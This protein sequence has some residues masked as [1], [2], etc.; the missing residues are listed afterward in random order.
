MWVNFL[1]Y[2][3]ES[4]ITAAELSRRSGIRRVDT[5]GMERWGYVRVIA[6]DGT[7]VRDL[8]ARAGVAKDITEVSL[9]Y[10]EKQGHAQVSSATGR[11]VAATTDAGRAAQRFAAERLDALDARFEAAREPLENILANTPALRDVLEPHPHSWRAIGPYA[12]QTRRML[13]DPR[14][15]LAHFP[16]VTH[17]GGYPD[18]S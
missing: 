17:R 4:G 14:A 13:A 9:G 18:G 1:R 7:P 5:G 6:L 8:A 15:A 12:A 3:G 10:L 2:V 16:I 11:K